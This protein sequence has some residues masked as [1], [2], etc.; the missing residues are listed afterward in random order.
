MLRCRDFSS[1]SL[2]LRRSH[3]RDA[4]HT[5][6]FS[7]GIERRCS[8]RHAYIIYTYSLS[9]A[10]GHTIFFDDFHLFGAVLRKW[11]FRM[12][13][14]AT[15]EH[16]YRYE[17]S[18]HMIFEFSFSHAWCV[19]GGI[20]CGTSSYRAASTVQHLGNDSIFIRLEI[21]MVFMAES[22]TWPVVRWICD[23]CE[24]KEIQYSVNLYTSRA[25]NRSGPSVFLLLPSSSLE[26]TTAHIRSTFCWCQLRHRYINL[27]LLAFYHFVWFV[28]KSFS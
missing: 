16:T 13:I 26:P 24:W 28:L 9:C 19:F 15:N 7:P 27:P 14:V 25:E 18:L 2:I 21:W 20:D 17:P 8:S 3:T 22:D 1:F 10:F 4:H 12:K 5:H 11:I 6:S 23:L